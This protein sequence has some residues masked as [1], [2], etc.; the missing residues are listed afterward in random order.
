MTKQLLGIP[1]LQGLVLAGTFLCRGWK[2]RRR[3]PSLSDAEPFLSP[4][5]SCEHLLVE[6]RA[7]ACGW[8][9]TSHTEHNTSPCPGVTC[10]SLQPL[11]RGVKGAPVPFLLQSGS[12]SLLQ[13]G[14]AQ[15]R[16]S[17]ACPAITSL[18]VLWI[19]AEFPPSRSS[20]TLFPAENPARASWN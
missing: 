6:P 20:W 16:A 15:L 10:C 4:S 5:G 13:Q 1:S 9:G 14:S 19:P 18:F 12:A 7:F 8:G 17:C 11:G 2:G 3:G